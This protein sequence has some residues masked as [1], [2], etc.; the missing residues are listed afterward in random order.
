MGFKEERALSKKDN[1]NAQFP[2]RFLNDI[3]IADAR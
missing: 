3:V 2:T 1:L